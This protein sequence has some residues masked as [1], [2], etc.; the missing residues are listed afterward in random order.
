MSR[1]ALATAA[2]CEREFNVVK[3]SK[4]VTILGRRFTLNMVPKTDRRDHFGKCDPPDKVGK[5][6]VVEGNHDDERVLNTMLHEMLHAGAWNLDEEMVCQWATDA[7]K[8][9]IRFGW[10][11]EQPQP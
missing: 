1:R 11:R 5:T 6:I 4:R 9:L 7:A 10:K 8:I 3:G 2:R